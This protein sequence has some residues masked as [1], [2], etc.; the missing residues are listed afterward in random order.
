MSKVISLLV[1]A[2]TTFFLA[3]S[4][5]AGGVQECPYP[6]G[7]SLNT[8][9]TLKG[10]SLDTK[11]GVFV[12]EFEITNQNDTESLTVSGVLSKR[13]DVIKIV[14]PDFAI[15]YLDLMNQWRP[16]VHLPGSFEG[17]SEKRVVKPGKS[18]AFTVPLM[19][20]AIASQNAKEFR[21]LLR[22]TSP[23]RCVVSEPFSGA[24]SRASVTHLVSGT[25][26]D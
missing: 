9:L 16:F 25:K 5:F 17:A 10:S 13:G 22:T 21:I 24:P 11:S 23:D 14:R 7:T 3:T 12:G 19:T 4:A 2:A 26:G 1:I 20:P 6:G 15:E 18:L 8:K